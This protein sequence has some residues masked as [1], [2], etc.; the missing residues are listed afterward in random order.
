[1]GAIAWKTTS[2]HA[3]RPAVEPVA[4]HLLLAP[5]C[6]EAGRVILQSLARRLAN[7]G[8]RGLVFQCL[9]LLD[10]AEEGMQ[11]GE[12]ISALGADIAGHLVGLEGGVEQAGVQVGAR[13]SAQASIVINSW[14]AA[15]LCPNHGTPRLSKHCRAAY[16]C[17]SDWRGL[18]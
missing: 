4:F 16:R 18:R 10:G 14:Q 1:M 17:K 8:G 6:H 11:A 2:S 15:S 13:R 5:R 3:G 7:R 9:G 12:H